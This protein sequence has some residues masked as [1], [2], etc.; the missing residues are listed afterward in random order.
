MTHSLALTLVVLSLTTTISITTNT[1]NTNNNITTNFTTNEFADYHDISS[2]LFGALDVKETQASMIIN[3]MAIMHMMDEL[4]EVKLNSGGG[5]SRGTQ[6]G[7][8]GRNVMEELS[9]LKDELQTL[10]S[11]LTKHA[12]ESVAQKT[13][14]VRTVRE[15]LA[16]VVT[17]QA[18]QR[19]QQTTLNQTQ[20][21]L[22]Q[23]QATLNRSQATLLSD[24]ATIHEGQTKLQENQVRLYQ[25]QNT[26]QE[27]QTT[28]QEKVDWLQQSLSRLL[29][30]QYTLGSSS[31]TVSER[32]AVGSAEVRSDVMEDG[33]L[34]SRDEVQ[35]ECPEGELI[36]HDNCTISECHQGSLRPY[37]GVRAPNLSFSSL[38]SKGCVYREETALTWDASRALCVAKGGDLFVPGDL[39]SLD[40]FTSIHPHGPWVGVRGRYWLDGRLVEAEAWDE[41]QPSNDV[42]DVDTLCGW[43]YPKTRRLY[44]APCHTYTWHSL[45]HIGVSYPQR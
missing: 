32:M 31:M 14:C 23:S 4:K 30:Q 33:V 6:H 1:S 22:Q 9:Q 25:S 7:G 8:C 21:T 16:L 24:L 17:S 43:I 12:D 2:D 35:E 38:V 5:G 3:Q 34:L 28:L 42:G 39:H 41:D 29:T 27:A 26:L 40:Q 18:R 44:D 45:C 36:L 15:D 37:Q 20:T 19:Q 11:S 10:K 13:S